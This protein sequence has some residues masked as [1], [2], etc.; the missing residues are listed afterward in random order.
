MNSGKPISFILSYSSSKVI[1]LKRKTARDVDD[2][3]LSHEFRENDQ[4]RSL[5]LL[6]SH[7]LEKKN[8]QIR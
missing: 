7:T 1:H 3:I 6:Q 5:L 2:L 4:F 8:S